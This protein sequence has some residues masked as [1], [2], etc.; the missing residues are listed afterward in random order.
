LAVARFATRV[1]NLKTSDPLALARGIIH[2]LINKL[3]DCD[4]VESLQ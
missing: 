1:T 2:E 3:L 4:D